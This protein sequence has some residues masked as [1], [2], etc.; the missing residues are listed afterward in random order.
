LIYYRGLL[1]ALMD[2][3]VLVC[4]DGATGQ[5]NYR[6]RLGGNCNSSPIA[7]DGHLFANNNDGQTFVVEA[8]P[9][10]KLV[11]TN[12]RG[13][14]VTASPAILGGQLIYRADSMLWRADHEDGDCSSPIGKSPAGFYD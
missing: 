10:F 4:H 6:K 11:A 9:A 12:N 1:Y 7:S 8:G 2:N 13:E 14:R 3:G 5:E